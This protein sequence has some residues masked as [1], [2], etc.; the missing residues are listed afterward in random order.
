M[1]TSREKPNGPVANPPIDNTKAILTKGPQFGQPEA[2]PDPREF[3]VKHASDKAAY[4]IL[5]KEPDQPPLPF[6]EASGGDEPTLTLAKVVGNGGKALVERIN[7]NGQIVFHA[8]G[9]TGNTRS[10]GPQNEVADKMV[11]DCDDLN[12]RNVPAFL[13]HLGDV[14]YSFGEAEYYYDQFYEPYRDYPLQSSRFPE[15]MMVWWR[16][17]LP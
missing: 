13:Y 15:T 7:K 10:T 3:L 17:A 14:V 12:P 11:S 1:N 5:D 2:T 4:A 6:P 16:L 9:D 8:V